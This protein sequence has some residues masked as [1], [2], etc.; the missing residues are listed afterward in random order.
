MY[1]IKASIDT[2]TA[3]GEFITSFEITKEDDG[4][5]LWSSETYS[6]REWFEDYKEIHDDDLGLEEGERADITV[7]FYDNPTAMEYDYPAFSDTVTVI[8]SG[9]DLIANDE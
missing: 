2:Y 5:Q 1:L 3:D 7:N 8:R 4:I 9:D 6:A